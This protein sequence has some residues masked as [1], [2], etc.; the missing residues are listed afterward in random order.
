MIKKITEL[1]IE[2]KYGRLDVEYD[3]NIL[4]GKILEMQENEGVL[5]PRFTC[6]NSL[7]KTPTIFG[8]CV[9]HEWEEE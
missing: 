2:A 3:V 7:N 6:V 4:A 5:P 8:S 1:L 9:L